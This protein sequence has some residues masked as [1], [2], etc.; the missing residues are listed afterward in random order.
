[1]YIKRELLQLDTTCAGYYNSLEV[2]G[3][4]GS[5]KDFQKGRGDVQTSCSGDEADFGLI[6][7][8][9]RCINSDADPIE[10]AGIFL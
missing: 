5:D 4:V 3:R 1:L 10:R 7:Y 8:V 9:L 6:L 2:V